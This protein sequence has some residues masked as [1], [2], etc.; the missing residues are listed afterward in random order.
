MTV[1]ERG[2]GVWG[3]RSSEIRC[4]CVL[5]TGTA[6]PCALSPSTRTP[7]SHIVQ[8]IT[9]KAIYTECTSRDDIIKENGTHP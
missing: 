2:R 1:I 9:S 4:F 8:E 5:K 3:E 7:G 6:I